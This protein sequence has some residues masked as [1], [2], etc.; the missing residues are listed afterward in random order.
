MTTL[1]LP[2]TPPREPGA[3]R[4][5]ILALMTHGLLFVL[6]FFGV[7][8][9]SQAPSVIEAELWSA[10]PEIAAPAPP[11][12]PIKQPVAP[13]EPPPPPRRV[14]PIK[15]P[16]P[17]KPDIALKQEPPKK[18][19]V[20]KPKT[21]E[22]VPVKVI[23][24]AVPKPVA[25][26]E[27][28]KQPVKQPAPAPKAAAAE[29]A[30]PAAPSDLANLLAAAARPSSGSAARNA[31]PRTDSGYE[32]AIRAKIL[33]NLRFPVPTDL[34]GN[35]EAI[36]VIE[37][38]PSGEIV[39]ITKRK[40]SGLPAFDSAVERAIEASSPLPRAADGRIERSLELV[41]KPLDKR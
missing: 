16:P 25:R 39:R 18:K 41:F 40:A 29:P 30:T 33:S 1:S 21:P 24:K 23:P 35:P 2:Y 6:L 19:P 38:L 5:L 27:P 28:A 11:P 17:A 26:P 20:V 4:A 32:N 8:W 31:G 7:R 10:S 3:S 37:Q 9:Q 15:E 13:P 22:K 36:F 12:P 34:A 14:E